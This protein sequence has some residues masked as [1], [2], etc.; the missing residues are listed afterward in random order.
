MAA[1]YSQSVTQVFSDSSCANLIGIAYYPAVE[2]GTALPCSPFGES[3]QYFKGICGEEGLIAP[4]EFV[5]ITAYPKD[6]N[7]MNSSLVQ[8]GKPDTCWV[9][10]VNGETGEISSI[11]FSACSEE[12]AITYTFYSGM[13][14]CQDSPTTGSVGAACAADPQYGEGVATCPIPAPGAAPTSAS[15]VAAPQ[16]ASAPTKTPSST[17]AKSDASAVIASF[18]FLVVAAFL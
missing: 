15:P 13:N 17:P 3:G 2:C 7:C 8:F 4:E 9:T 12:G 5:A 18:V 16:S 10:S 11:K 14:L 1:A 6:N